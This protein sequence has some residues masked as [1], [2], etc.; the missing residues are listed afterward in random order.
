VRR[1]PRYLRGRGL[2]QHTYNDLRPHEA[3]NDE[4]PASRWAPSARA[5]PERIAPPEYPGHVE[6]RR[7]STA[8][9]FRLHSGQ[10]FLSQALNEECVGF[11]EVQ[12]GLWN[13]LYYTTLLGRVDERTHSITGAPSL[14]DKC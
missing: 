3:L 4:T 14:K 5:Y 1:R 10:Y 13:I 12:D 6:V 2:R 7:I 11:E 8:G 9:T